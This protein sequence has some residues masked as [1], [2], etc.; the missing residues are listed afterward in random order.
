MV[1]VALSYKTETEKYIMIYEMVLSSAKFK[2]FTG[3]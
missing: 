3:T 2:D 1:E